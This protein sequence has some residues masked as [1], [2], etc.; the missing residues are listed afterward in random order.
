MS[1]NI[2]FTTHTHNTFDSWSILCYSIKIYY[3]IKTPIF[4]GVHMFDLLSIIWR[5]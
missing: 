4:Q 2:S 5:N 3:N 1:E